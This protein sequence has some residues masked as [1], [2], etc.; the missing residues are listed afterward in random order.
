MRDA[1]L[2]DFA[3]ESESAPAEAAGDN[4]STGAMAPR[5]DAHP[6]SSQLRTA[7]NAP[8]KT[9]KLPRPTARRRARSCASALPRR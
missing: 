1:S 2:C 3:A 5:R 7:R 9:P 6:M 8:A 4:A